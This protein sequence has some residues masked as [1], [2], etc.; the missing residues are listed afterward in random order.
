MAPKNSNSKK[1]QGRARK[2]ESEDKKKAAVTVEK[3]KKEVEEWSKGSKPTNKTKEEKEAKK[4][5][6]A[7]RKAENAKL[8]AEE[9]E[10]IAMKKPVQKAPKGASS[11]KS[12]TPASRHAGLGPLAAAKALVSPDP[13]YTSFSKGKEKESETPE[14]KEEAESLSATGLDDAL[15]M[16]TL[17]T[18]KTD[19]ASVGQQAA[20]LEAHPERRFKAAFEAYLERELPSTREEHPGLRL[21]QYREL[22][23]KQFQKAPE[24]PFNQTLVSYN[25]TNED[26]VSTLKAERQRVEERLRSKE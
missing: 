18:A 7:A 15:D 11:K 12:I 25:A 19:K 5:A 24:N 2:A 17:V 23:F 10:G 20:K 9:E 13:L 26:K 16:M 22:L 6:D 8:I 3:E 21:N 4:A 1:E 14:E